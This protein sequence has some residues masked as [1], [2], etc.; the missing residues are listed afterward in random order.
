M[1]AK[2]DAEASG[3]TWDE[4]DEVVALKVRR[5]LDT[6]VP[7]RLPT[8]KYLALREAATELGIGPSTLIRMWVFEKLRSN[9]GASPALAVAVELFVSNK[10]RTISSRTAKLNP[11]RHGVEHRGSHPHNRPTTDA[12]VRPPLPSPSWT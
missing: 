12:T 1:T 4:A 6:I 9:L 8:E 10:P 11:T 3:D 7:V 2:K 5:P